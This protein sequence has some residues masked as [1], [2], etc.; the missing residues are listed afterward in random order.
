MNLTPARLI[1]KSELPPVSRRNG[2]SSLI[3]L[4]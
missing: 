2:G 3:G 1:T 4:Y